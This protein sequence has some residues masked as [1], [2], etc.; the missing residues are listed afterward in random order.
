M[1]LMPSVEEM[2]KLFKYLD[3]TYKA[4]MVLVSESIITNFCFSINFTQ[5]YSGQVSLR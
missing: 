4:E 3:T 5:S 2:H 1:S